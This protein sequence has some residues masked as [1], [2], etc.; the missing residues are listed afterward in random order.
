MQNNANQTI[1]SIKVPPSEMNPSVVAAAVAATINSPLSLK[2]IRDKKATDTAN[3]AKTLAF[4]L[5]FYNALNMGQYSNN[6]LY[7]AAYDR[8]TPGTTQLI[9]R[10]MLLYIALTGKDITDVDMLAEE[11]Y[12]VLNAVSFS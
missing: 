12:Q 5:C 8:N 7:R 3:T 4:N 2:K 1:A 10:S 11:V 6:Q 9:L